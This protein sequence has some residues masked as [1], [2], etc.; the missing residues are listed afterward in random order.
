[1]NATD[2]LNWTR[3]H[4][5]AAVRPIM[6][7]LERQIDLL[8]S[9]GGEGVFILEFFEAAMNNHDLFNRVKLVHVAQFYE[10]I[11]EQRKREIA[12]R[13][14]QCLR[15]IFDKWGMNPE[16]LERMYDHVFAHGLHTY[17]PVAS[18]E[19]DVPSGKFQEVSIYTETDC[20]RVA[21]A[22]ARGLGV[23]KK[24]LART[25][26]LDRMFAVG[27]DFRPGKPS[28]FK[29]YHTHP[30]TVERL[31]RY[32]SAKPYF[33]MPKRMLPKEYLVLKRK[34]EG[35][36]FEDTRKVYLPY[37]ARRSINE[38]HTIFGM[39]AHCRKGILKDF[40]KNIRHT[41]DGTFLD[42]IGC[43]GTKIEVYY[44]K[45]SLGWSEESFKSGRA[46]RGI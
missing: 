9:A 19:W 8:T 6:R 28:R 10:Q 44:G 39:A 34:T 21:A 11:R 40:F 23:P 31:R 42:Y 36:D 20:A 29:L 17:Y 37:L 2:I 16:P 7:D 12:R 32:S 4:Y 38:G 45:P 27:Y 18:V 25:L 14:R 22:I 15:E 41:A 35:E 33:T 5:G 13:R 46:M 3:H 30:L 24:G 43:E 26:G 1:M